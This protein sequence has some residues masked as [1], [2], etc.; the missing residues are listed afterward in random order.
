MEKSNFETSVLRLLSARYCEERYRGGTTREKERERGGGEKE[1]ERH[2]CSYSLVPVHTYTVRILP[3]E[4]KILC[5]LV[6][7]ARFESQST[8]FSCRWESAIDT[9][10][11]H[12]NNTSVPNSTGVLQH[13]QF[14]LKFVDLL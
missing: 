10:H 7:A 14:Q 3:E 9:T 6:T 13:L 2:H 1:G 4:T 8:A 11:Q 5:N 12:N